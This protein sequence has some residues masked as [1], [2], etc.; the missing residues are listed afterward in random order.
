MVEGLKIFHYEEG[1]VSFS[2]SVDASNMHL[3]YKMPVWIATK[4]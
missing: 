4:Q 1:E 3:F 2:S